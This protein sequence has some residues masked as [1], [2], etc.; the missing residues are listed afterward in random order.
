MVCFDWLSLDVYFCLW[1]GLWLFC[2]GGVVLLFVI[3]LLASCVLSLYRFYVLFLRYYLVSGFGLC[4][5]LF[6]DLVLL[7]LFCFVLFCCL[8]DW[9]GWFFV[10]LWALLV[11]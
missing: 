9:V 7:S 8:F 5:L 11:W 6:V 4:L 10:G 2:L 3:G 1:F